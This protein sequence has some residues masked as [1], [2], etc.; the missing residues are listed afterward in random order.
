M[1]NLIRDR[2]RDVLRLS[3]GNTGPSPGTMAKTARTRIAIGI[4]G[5][6]VALPEIGIGTQARHALLPQV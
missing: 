1:P 5:R 3:G 6:A 2:D 4:A